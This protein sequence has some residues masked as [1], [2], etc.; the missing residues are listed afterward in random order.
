MVSSALEPE[1]K[2]LVGSSVKKDKE[3]LKTVGNSKKIILLGQSRWFSCSACSQ[4][5]I[6]PRPAFKNIAGSSVKDFARTAG[7]LP[8]ALEIES[9]NFAGSSVKDSTDS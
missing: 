4:L 6:L 5:L 3:T 1:V 8:S 7:V 2:I 9:E